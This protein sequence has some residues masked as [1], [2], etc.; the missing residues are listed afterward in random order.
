MAGDV[1]LA[2]A[3]IVAVEAVAVVIIVLLVVF[4]VVCNCFDV[5]VVDVFGYFMISYICIL[6]KPFLK[7][8]K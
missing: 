8:L 1:V 3:V 4:D 2:V 6:S 5:F 7:T